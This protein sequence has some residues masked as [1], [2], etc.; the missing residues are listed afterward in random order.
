MDYNTD[1]I[2]KIGNETMEL[3]SD[4]EKVIL[5][6]HGMETVDS[7][8]S[9]DFDVSRE[10]LSTSSIPLGAVERAG[11]Y[12]VEDLLQYGSTSSGGSGGHVTDGISDHVESNLP[13]FNQDVQQP[14][15]LGLRADQ[16]E[17][18]K[19]SASLK[20]VNTGLRRSVPQSSSPSL[21]VG[22]VT[23]S[24]N[25]NQTLHLGHKATIMSDNVCGFEDGERES[26]RVMELGIT[27]T[28]AVDMTEVE[29]QDNA[30]DLAQEEEEA[31]DLDSFVNK[32]V[33]DLLQ[34]LRHE[35]TNR[36]TSHSMF[37]KGVARISDIDGAMEDSLPLDFV[38]DFL[39]VDQ[40]THMSSGIV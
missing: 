32:E 39:E 26:V 8:L 9:D 38:E 17:S 30:T 21:S 7:V 2:I 28:T 1:S 34:E 6:E 20:S 13:R 36:E 4:L 29:I 35:S 5:A 22:A 19:L 40:T 27:E 11:E 14:E 16:L 10:D 33:S 31:V 15:T 23:S 37:V 12:N 18:E 3:E 25:D 24:S